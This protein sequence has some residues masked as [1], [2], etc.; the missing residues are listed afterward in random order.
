M[1][2]LSFLYL[3]VN[4]QSE[5]VVALNEEFNQ[6]QYAQVLSMADQLRLNKALSKT[7]RVEVHELGIRSALELQQLDMVDAYFKS[8]LK[9]DPQYKPV[10]EIVEERFISYFNKY[11]ALPLVSFTLSFATCVPRM[12]VANS[13]SVNPNL[14]YANS[15]YSSIV[16]THSQGRLA[17]FPWKHHRLAI[18]L[19]NP[20]FISTRR[21]DAFDGTSS[22]STDNVSF[23]EYSEE[24][25]TALLALNYGWYP[26]RTAAFGYGLQLGGASYFLREAAGSAKVNY[27]SNSTLNN[28]VSSRKLRDDQRNFIVGFADIGAEIYVNKGSIGLSL[29]THYYRGLSLYNDPSKRFTDAELSTTYQYVDDD[30]YTDLFT[31]TLGAT[32]NFLYRVR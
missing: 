9:I 22:D 18:S 13:F 19:A 23:V 1:S 29:E 32:Y 12:R 10:P 11:E 25:K 3:E 7:E 31:V 4:A 28:I 5:R 2:A 30:L 20:D 14:D 17:F 27:S 21:I 8:L 6:R 16:W 24:T 26:T 15:D